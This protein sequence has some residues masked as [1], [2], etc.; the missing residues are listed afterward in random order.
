MQ[1]ALYE[2]LADVSEQ[3]AVERARGGDSW[4]WSGRS[5]HMRTDAAASSQVLEFLLT[6]QNENQKKFIEDVPPSLAQDLIRKSYAD[7]LR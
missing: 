4:H 7:V 2:P 1:A 3:Y 6:Q 5:N